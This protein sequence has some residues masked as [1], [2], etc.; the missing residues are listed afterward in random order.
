MSLM[1][2]F[3]II[4]IIIFITACG[5][6]YNSK[7]REALPNREGDKKDSI[8]LGKSDTINPVSKSINKYYPFELLEVEG[9]Y[10]IIAQIEGQDLFPKYYSFFQKHQ[11]EGNGYCWEGHIAQILEKIDKEL[12]K[13]IY[14]DS[15][16]GGFFAT[17]D[18][19]SNQIKFVELLSP[20]FSDL[21]KLEL[22]IKK[23]DRSK[24]DD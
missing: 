4:S 16:G 12:L 17:A 10:E 20:I 24:I 14:F 5:E 6:K 22:W 3:K 8:I 15:E 23:A 21:N 2:F 13:H 7:D 18:T 19:K 1:N 11:Y 9:K